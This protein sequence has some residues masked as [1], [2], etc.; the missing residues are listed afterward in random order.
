MG[1]LLTGKGAG[2]VLSLG[3]LALAA[4]ALTPLQF[5]QF[6]LI[7]S[8]AQAVSALVGF[9]SWQIVIRYG[10]RHI[11]TGDTPALGRLVRFCLAL[12][13]MGAVVG[14]A[15][16]A[17]VIAV[18]QARLGWSAGLARDALLFSI[19]LLLSI[20]STAVGVLR[21]HDRFARGVLA[22]AVTPVTRLTGAIA[23][24]A[25]GASVT[26]FLIAWAVA[27]ALTAAVYWVSAH[28][29]APCLL[30]RWRQ[31]GRTP[32]DH[33]GFW[34]FAA[35]TNANTTLNAAGRQFMVVLIGFTVG[36]VAAGGYRLAY[37]LSQALVR[38]S[39][40]FARGVFPE[41]A[42]AD[43][44]ATR[45]DLRVLFRQIARLAVAAGLAI[46]IL[47]P[48]L[49]K[50]AL[51]LIGGETYLG[52]Y[53]ILVLLSIAAG[54]EVMAVG[55]EPLLVATGRAG[56]ALRIRAISVALLIAVL[57]LFLPR[58][59]VIA[60]GAATL[61]SSALSL[62]LFARSARKAVRN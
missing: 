53:P 36:A 62:V 39:D 46:C 20:R 40:L 49:G 52:A 35:A 15:I 2:A 12:D 32:R 23:A 11:Q 59:G 19:V 34:R 30:G 31:A 18:M 3:Y 47:A 6:M 17:G 60:A 41:I 4:R 25:A 8:V 7:L 45:E 16:A 42:R 54:L 22:D 13:M 28:R 21:L 48:L 33:P 1:W 27:E 9:Q 51:W 44:A 55:F 61:A 24:V 10:M 38:V 56:T 5:G 57:A 58:Y 50:P 14:C 37:Q 43:G 26:G 29:A